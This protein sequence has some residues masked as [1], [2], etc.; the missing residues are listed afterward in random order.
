[1]A[2]TSIDTGYVGSR[3]SNGVVV[4]YNT[5]NVGS[6]HTEEYSNPV[7]RYFR[8]KLE[9][10]KDIQPTF[11]RVYAVATIETKISESYIRY[12]VNSRGETFEYD[13]LAGKYINGNAT[14]A[15]EYILTRADDSYFS[16]DDDLFPQS[17]YLGL[18]NTRY[19]ATNWVTVRNKDSNSIYS[20]IVYDVSFT[21]ETSSRT[22]QV[23]SNRAIE[24]WH[25]L[26]DFPIYSGANKRDIIND[27][28]HVF[29]DIII[30]A[31]DSYSI[32][33]NA[34]G[35][36]G[37]FADTTI[38]YGRTA[39]LISS[40]PTR[41]GYTFMGW[42]TKQDG[43]GTTYAS[44]ATYTDTLHSNVTLYAKWHQNPIIGTRG[45]ISNNTYYQNAT[46]YGATVTYSNATTYDNATIS[47]IYLTL[48][49]GSTSQSSSNKTSASGSFTIVPNTTG[50]NV[51][52]TMTILD[53]FGSATSYTVGTGI[54]VKHNTP[55]T[56]TYTAPTATTYCQSS[57]N[58]PYTV[59][60]KTA[61]AYEGKSVT[62]TTN[63][64]TLKIGTVS[65]S[66]TWAGSS[67]SI[68]V[69]P[70]ATGSNIVPTLRIVDN[71]GASTTYN[72]PAITVNADSNPTATYS[73]TAPSTTYYYFGKSQ[74]KVK[75]NATATAP[76]TITQ[77]KAT[78]T[79]KSGGGATTTLTASSATNNS[80]LT[81]NFANITATTAK[82]TYTVALEAT[83]RNGKKW[84]QTG[85]E[86]TVYPS[87]QPQCT[88]TVPSR[89]AYYINPITNTA[90]SE[91]S[92]NITGVTLGETKVLSQITLKVGSQT[93]SI[94]TSTG[95]L[96]IT[97]N[98]ESNSITPQIIITDTV[99]D[100]RTYN[101]TAI[102]VKANTAPTIST[103]TVTSSTPYYE[104]TPSAART[105]YSVKV[106]SITISN[107][108][109]LK[110]IILTLGDQSTTVTSLT[111]GE[112]TLTIT[113][114]K[115]GTFV[116][117]LTITD[118]TGDIDGNSTTYNLN[119]ITVQ[120]RTLSSSDHQ[121]E[122]T[123][124]SGVPQDTGSYAIIKVTISYSRYTN[125]K[126]L[127]PEL[128]VKSGNNTYTLSGNWYTAW[129]RENGVSGNPINWSSGYYPSQS[130][131]TL[132][133]LFTI[134]GGFL[135]T[136]TY[137]FTFKPKSTASAA[138][139]STI[140]ITLTP[141]FYL[142]AG[143]AGG[144]ALGIGKKATQDG[145]LDV[146]M[147]K[148]VMN[149]YNNLQPSISY[150]NSSNIITDMIT[151]ND[152]GVN[153][154]ASLRVNSNTYNNGIN[155][156]ANGTTYY[157]DNSAIARLSKSEFYN[158]P[159]ITLNVASTPWPYITFSSRAG[160]SAIGSNNF[161]YTTITQSLWG[162]FY[163]QIPAKKITYATAGDTSSTV[164]ATSYL[165]AKFWFRQYSPTSTGARTAYYEDYGL[166]ATTIDRTNNGSYSI[167]TSKNAVTIAQGG[168][169]K[170]TAKE[171]AN[172]LIDALDTAT[173]N[174]T[175]NTLILTSDVSGDTD[176]YYR[177]AA[178][179]A[180]NY[181][182]S[183][184]TNATLKTNNILTLYRE[185]TT[186]NNYP[187]GIKFSVKD[188]TTG[189]TNNSGFIYAYQDHGT[190][191][192]SNNNPVSYGVNM[193]IQPG[194]NLF[195]GS[196]ESPDAHYKASYISSTAEHTF[197]TADSNVF[198]QANGNTIANRLGFYLNTSHQ[199]LPCKA[200]AATNN[201]GSIGNSSYRWA[202]IY[203]G[204]IDL[205][206][207]ITAG[208]AS[209]TAERDV[210]ASSAAGRIYLY[211]AG[212]NTGNRGIYGS[213][214]AGTGHAVITI[215]Q[216]NVIHLPGGT[217]ADG[218]L[219]ASNGYV[220]S[221]GGLLYST[222]YGN[223]VAIGSQN[224]GFCH[225]YN[226]ASIPFAFNQGFAMVNN[227]TIGTT[228]YPTGNII[229][230][231]QAKLMS[232]NGSDPV[233]LI[234]MS[235]PDTMTLGAG[236]V[237]ATQVYGDFFPSSNGSKL[238]VSGNRWGTI[239]ATNGTI[240]TSDKKDKDIL[241]NIINAKDL[242]LNLK[243]INYMWKD[244]DHRRIRMGFIAQDVALICK[245]LN[246]NLALI[247]A[248]YKDC[249][250][251]PY[252]GEEVDDVLLR[253]GL[254]YKELIAPMVAVIQEQE[255]EIQQLKQQLSSIQQHLNLTE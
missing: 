176:L 221:N 216:N 12:H 129:S 185:G 140:T 87:T 186:A 138:T 147:E 50:T 117:T 230:K 139:V 227:G 223:E 143:R 155:Y 105:N 23:G 100:S 195:I 207:N 68:S 132:Y 106:S 242:I 40:K 252:Y 47:K 204:A 97:L 102:S 46:G 211:S 142:L 212:S 99:G 64:V 244:G 162:N 18:N 10:Y 135:E 188:T 193:V 218:N 77:I 219:I 187:A 113:P 248:H 51:T 164:T 9:T 158:S 225:I 131:V 255:Q 130:S 4:G 236:A 74:F 92:V 20:R 8:C 75:I 31:L 254:N 59:T 154:K 41:S 148:I 166:P 72:L 170:T 111:N 19:N 43:T 241:G 119:S 224:E 80:T 202:S 253:W 118:K 110:N 133:G 181:I 189:A 15:I 7:Y 198:I 81:I 173:A 53:S 38:Y 112:A 228:G 165:A 156:F 107:G 149:N 104:N 26:D 27:Q 82:T 137:I 85:S 62:S 70:N 6:G 60:V 196:G 123:T 249:E 44:G 151:L 114:N 91:Y 214:A 199:L 25:C 239:Y 179:S 192:D 167:L 16:T 120:S 213:N 109:T 141:A 35:G 160:T 95:K 168:T 251:K 159:G 115:A 124:S 220:W 200:D 22:Q 32:S 54:T 153:I 73:I 232:M 98:T 89:T 237:Q 21:R 205:T 14:G 190:S 11:V 127:Q 66:I 58:Y 240:N 209:Q 183:K 250:N 172:T 30:P 78:L 206:G 84:T 48:K 83:D 56:C 136:N 229:M 247:D 210:I 243:P 67:T 55:P 174:W 201:V 180:W 1:M 57:N 69:T 191:V 33:Y 235:G 90:T 96:T 150:R 231:Y 2:A 93:T 246:K 86:I 24:S 217:T 125:N 121:V 238:G 215:G 116:P 34:N 144:H 76:K 152:S 197:I 234:R 29:S 182:N 134:N 37:I 5:L 233:S 71:R 175:D 226:S 103:R 108:K 177:R 39:S 222:A 36:D 42:N 61:T 245:R 63:N 126:L 52:A 88:Y 45:S 94:S 65:K 171:A 194:G 122:R 169:G 145:I 28:N 184:L 178:T 146:G 79:P 163:Y 13:G 101:L 203:A 49:Y 161:T 17:Y 3:I 128:T 208:N 157:I